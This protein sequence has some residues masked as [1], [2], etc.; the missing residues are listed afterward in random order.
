MIRERHIKSGKLFEADFYP[1]FDNG[2]RMPSRARKSHPSTPE[3][4]RYNKK[5]AE[6]KLVRLINANFDE[7]D[8]IMHPT[9]V[10]A[11]AP[12]SETEARRDIVN[13]MRRIRTRRESELKRVRAALAALP[14]SD[15]LKG[16]RKDLKRR[17][18]KLEAPFRYIYV[19]ERVQYKSGKYK[20]GNN[21]HFHLVLSGGIDRRELEKM[22]PCG[23]RTNA[24]AFQ[25]EK[26]GPEAIAKYMA[27]DCQ[28]SK[29]IC[30]SRNLQKPKILKPKDGKISPRGVEKL[31]REKIDDRAWW[32]NRYKGYRFLSAR[33][34]YNDYNGYWYLS[35]TMYRTE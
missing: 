15:A 28:G 19:I 1:V 31:A 9:Y 26:F 5:Q 12:R 14:Q 20:G 23:I 18:A 33:A 6:K 24:D 30:H 16:Q 10:Q 2:K 13:F 17:I 7:E 22:W 25:P 32:E 35:V 34:M 29:R 11:L 8:V 27:K 21:W 3:Q 4:E